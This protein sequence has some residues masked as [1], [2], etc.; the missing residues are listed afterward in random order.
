MNFD[1]VFNSDNSGGLPDWLTQ[2]V[3]LYQKVTGAGGDYGPP[4]SGPVQG[5]PTVPGIPASMPWIIGGLVL[6]ALV[7]GVKGRG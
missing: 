5:P 7:F 3:D 2:G 4:T 6:A 1:D